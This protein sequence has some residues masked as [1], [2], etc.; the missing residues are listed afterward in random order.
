MR[1]LAYP[2]KNLR[3]RPG[4]TIFAAVGVALAIATFVTMTVV[5]GRIAD[6]WQAA[7]DEAGFHLV[8]V[9]ETQIDWLASSVPDTLPAEIAAL[10]SVRSVDG[11]LVSF[12][13]TESGTAVLVSAW[14]PD[15]PRWQALQLIAGTR[16]QPGESNKAVIGE[17]AAS[18]LQLGVGDVLDLDGLRVEIS[19]IFKARDILTSGVLVLPLQTLQAQMFREGTITF[20]N[21]ALRQPDDPQAVDEVETFIESRYPGLAVRS[22]AQLSRDNRVIDFLNVLRHAVIWIVSLVGIAGTANIMLMAVN[23]RLSEIGLLVAVGWSPIRIV[24]VFVVE[25]IVLC[26]IS[27]LAGIA[28]G[29][30]IVELARSSDTLAAFLS[31]TMSVGV[32]LQGLAL[33]VGI[34]TISSVLP[35][36]RA[37]TVPADTALRAV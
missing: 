29:M 20:V 18:A 37:L 22:T 17:S 12:L 10:P 5:F 33:A 6:Q 21:V 31:D 32:G 2:I 16:P 4:R 15:S 36:L 26:T 14:S 19:G 24:T 28:L 11:E 13:T 8:V 34:G 35:A 9:Q 25:G 30:V 23:E 1:F 3:R 7:L 27:G